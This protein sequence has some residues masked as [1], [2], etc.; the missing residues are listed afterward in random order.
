MRRLKATFRVTGGEEEATEFCGLQIVRDWNAR[1]ITLTQEAFARKM[2][3]KYGVSGRAE[4]TPLKV[5]KSKL[6]PYT[7]EPCEETSFDY[8][9]ALGDLA[10]YARTNP[11]LSVAVHKLAQFMQRPGPDHIEA[12]HHV[13]RYVQGNLGA[14]LTYHGSSEVLSQSYD[15]R[16]KLIAT[17]DSDFPHT[18]AKAT[19]GV[20]VMLNGAAI[21]WKT[22]R[23]TTVSINSTE[24][25]VK[26]MEPGVQMV[27]WLTD[28]WAE[29]MRQPHGCVRVMDDSQGGVSQV[30]HG[31]DNAKCA[32][33]KKAQA[34]AEDAVDHGVLWFDRVPGEHNPSDLLTKQVGN[35][36]EFKYKN[37]IMCGSKPFLY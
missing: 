32:S 1:T 33:Y 18:G 26:A 21:A 25:E 27:R 14:G 8:S 20:A 35:I 3:A 6:E 36:S 19:S 29:F 28:L 9:M 30:V 10:W 37:G 11:G 5:S 22:R 34:Y 15:H 7:G 31:M 13:L 24:A 4:A 23:L 12:V 17:F 2:L 16:S